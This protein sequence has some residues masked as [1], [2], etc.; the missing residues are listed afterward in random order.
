MT[1]NEYGYP[2]SGRRKR[3]KPLDMGVN[4]YSDGVCFLMGGLLAISTIWL[5]LDVMSTCWNYLGNIILVLAEIRYH[6]TLFE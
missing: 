2:K 1:S 4:V 6:G 3:S 5:G